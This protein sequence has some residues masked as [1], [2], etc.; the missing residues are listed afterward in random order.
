MT[1]DIRAILES[2]HGAIALVDDTA[3]PVMTNA[4][5]DRLALGTVRGC[6]I[7]DRNGARIDRDEM[8][9]MRAA[10]AESTDLQLT[11]LEPGGRTWQC[12]TTVRPIEQPS[13]SGAVG[14]VAFYDVGPHQTRLFDEHAVAC[15][16]HDM[17]TPLVSLHGYA[18][19]LTQYLDDGQLPEEARAAALRIQSLSTRIGRMVDDLLDMARISEGLL[20]VAR[21]PIDMRSVVRDAVEIA[22]V[23]P[24]APPIHMRVPESAAVVTGD[25]RRL[26]DA[27][28]N[29]ITNAI[30]HAAETDCIEVRLEGH[31]EEIHISVEDHGPGIPTDQLPL[32]FGRYVQVREPGDKVSDGLGLGLFIAQQYVAAHDGRIDVVSTVGVGTRFVIRLPRD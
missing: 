14:V 26:G 31:D 5:F 17:R 20:R 9:L 15:V 32:V 24:G 4:A 25:A 6:T 16:S 19:I 1:S 21:E 2:V 3:S 22:M 7:L 28:L 23:A 8:P 18:E 30:K 11:V 10:R 12:R 27:L 29:L 13:V